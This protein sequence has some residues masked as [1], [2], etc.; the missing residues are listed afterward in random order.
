VKTYW[1]IFR[2]ALK[3]DDDRWIYV[4]LPAIAVAVNLLGQ[5]WWTALAFLVAT[6]TGLSRSLDQFDAKTARMLYRLVE[7]YEKVEVEGNGKHL[8]FYT[9]GRKAKGTK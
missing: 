9:I 5:Q 8:D 1:K 4:Y 6:S 3:A 7:R 2:A